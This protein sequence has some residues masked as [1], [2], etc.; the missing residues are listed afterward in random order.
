MSS[1]SFSK[2]S[3]LFNKSNSLS[4]P[5]TSDDFFLNLSLTFSK[6]CLKSSYFLTPSTSLYAEHN[7]LFSI[8]VFVSAKVTICSESKKKKRA[9]SL[10]NTKSLI[11]TS[12]PISAVSS[13]LAPSIRISTNSFS[14]IIS[15]VRIIFNVVQGRDGIT[16]SANSIDT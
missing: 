7:R 6:L 9:I 14:I 8:E 13:F 5:S 11:N 4:L 12:D 2:H 16:T 10:F 3:C 15:Y 1:T